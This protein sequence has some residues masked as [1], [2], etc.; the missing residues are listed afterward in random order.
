MKFIFIF[1]SFFIIQSNLSAGPLLAT[2]WEQ[3]S[4]EYKAL[5]YQAY[6]VAKLNLDNVLKE[7]HKKPLAVVLDVDKTVLSHKAFQG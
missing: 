3:D 1:S 4:A 5:C 6:N 7:K 2:L